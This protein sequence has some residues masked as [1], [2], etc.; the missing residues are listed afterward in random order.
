MKKI[1]FSSCIK[2]NNKIWFMSIEGY[3][4]NLDCLTY[5]TKIIV[6]SNLA[7]LQFEQVVD[8]MVIINN[9]LYFVEQNGAWLYEYDLE[10]NNCNCYVIP[11][12][13]YIAWGCFAGVYLF[14]QFIY[15]FARTIGTIFRFNTIDKEFEILGAEKKGIVIRSCCIENKVYLYG[16][17]IVCFDMMSG[18]FDQEYSIEEDN[19]IYLTKCEGKFYYVMK[20]RLS[21]WDPV[22]NNKINLYEEKEENCDTEKFGLFF[23]TEQKIFI[24]PSESR[25]VLILDRNSGG[26][27]R[28]IPPNDLVYIEKGWS[29]YWGYTEDDRCIWCANR[30]CNYILCI[31]KKLE[32][33]QWIKLKLPESREEV[34]YLKQKMRLANGRI[35][36]EGMMSLEQYILG[37]R[38]Q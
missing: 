20:D 33:I 3:L 34:P 8:D 38:E 26:L 17:K 35:Y 24:L 29:K 18:R 16:K 2:A 7:E 22:T 32:E 21:I 6:P 27:M 30:V 9:K 28:D 11:S 14:R 25:N 37:L 1:N 5:E 31:D 19:I 23:L 10:E 15:L 4:M 36:Y 13:D 12:T